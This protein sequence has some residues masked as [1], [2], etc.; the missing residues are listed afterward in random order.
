MQLGHTTK[1]YAMFKMQKKETFQWPVSVNIPKDGGGFNTHE[2]TGEFKLQ[3]QSR[4]DRLLELSKTDDRDVL[5]ELLVGWAG[6]QDS[7]GEVLAF[8]EENR[9]QLIDIPYVRSALL[10]CYFDAANGTKVKRGN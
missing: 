7:N 4:L 8:N 10:K 1:E 9:D 6:V 3:E 2:F 5:K